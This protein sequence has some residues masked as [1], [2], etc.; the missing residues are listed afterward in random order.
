[1][2]QFSALLNHI[3]MAK[4]ESPAIIPALPNSSLSPYTTEEAQALQME[5]QPSQCSFTDQHLSSCKQ[6]T[7]LLISW[8]SLSFQKVKQSPRP[9]VYEH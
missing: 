6:C 7:Q 9:Q 2:L 4:A 5:E 3:H 8:S 1:M